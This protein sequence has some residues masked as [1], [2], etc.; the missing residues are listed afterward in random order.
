[1]DALERIEI[2]IK[3]DIS[4]LLGEKESLAH[5]NEIR[6]D[7]KFDHK[8]WLEKYESLKNQSKRLD[9]VTHHNKHYNGKLPIWV[10]SEVWD[11]G[12]LSKLYAGMK[13]KDKDKIARKYRLPSGKNLETQLH[14][15][16]VIRNISAHHGRLW[17]RNAIGRVSLKGITD[18]PELKTL[19]SNQMFMYFCL[20]K[21]ML[22]TICPQ[23]TWGNRFSALIDEFPKPSNGAF[24]ID[25]FGI[26][27]ETNFKS[28]KLW[29][30]Q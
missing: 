15:F 10:A 18:P 5:T 14:A 28:W 1:M 25:Q 13:T 22:D 6:F 7:N 19:S 9:F 24:T 12:S 20:M 2:A 3:V 26:P 29:N 4:Y 16:N 11:F 27:K 8:K 17:N 21:R 30:A 23:S